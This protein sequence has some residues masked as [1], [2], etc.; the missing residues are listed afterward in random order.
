MKK[1]VLFTVVFAMLIW[2]CAGC[3]KPSDNGE[4]GLPESLKTI[5]DIMDL[6]EKDDESAL[7]DDMLIYAFMLNG[8]LYQA[9]VTLSQET[10]DALWDLDL[11]EEEDAEKYNSIVSRLVI[12]EIVDLETKKLSDDEM[13]ALEGKT[14]GDLLNSNWYVVGYDL[15]AMVFMM[16]YGPFTYNVVFDGSVDESDYDSFFAEE[17]ITGMTVKSVEYLSVGDATAID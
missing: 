5:G 17:D 14:G 7:Y 12:D 4:N 6:N 2:A 8:K 11:F 15:S 10:R 9:R 3:S 16:D 1:T 13:R